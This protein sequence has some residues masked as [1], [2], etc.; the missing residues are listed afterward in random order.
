[1]LT[2]DIPQNILEGFRRLQAATVCGIADTRRADPLH[3][4]AVCVALRAG[5]RGRIIPRINREV[6]I[7]GLEVACGAKIIIIGRKSPLGNLHHL[8]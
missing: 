2:L 3:N 8:K 1:M 6:H 5:L 7:D 4:A